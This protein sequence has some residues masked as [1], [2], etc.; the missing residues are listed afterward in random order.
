MFF[1]LKNKIFF[2]E[3]LFLTLLSFIPLLWFKKEQIIVGLDSGYAIDHVNYLMQRSNTW[4]GS[5]NFGV[6]MSSEVGIVPYNALPAIIK[7]LGVSDDFIQPILFVLWFFVLAI[8]MYL[9]S[10]CIFP[11]KNQW[12]ARM[13]S[14]II[15]IF[16]LHIYSFWLQG[17]QPIFASYAILP[18]FTMLFLR[19]AQRQSGILFT[20]IYLNLVYLFFSSGGMRGLPLIGPVIISS[21]LIIIYFFILSFKK[22]KFSY[23]FRFCKLAVVSIIFLFFCNAYFLLPFLSS[24]AF[25][26]DAQVVSAG[27]INSAIEWTKFI[28][29]YASFI[30]LFRLEGDPNWYDKPLIWS[31]NYLSNPILIFGSFIFPFLAFLSPLL[32]KKNQE[33]R[34]VLFFLLLS[35]LGVLFAAGAHMPL[36]FI[37][38]FLMEHIPGFASFRSAYYKFIPLVY[39]SFAILIGTTVYYLTGKIPK[40]KT[41]LRIG[42]ILLVLFYNY[43]FFSNS[44]FEF[45]KPFSTMVKI[46][47]YIREFSKFKNSTENDYRT[48]SVPPSSDAFSVKTFNWGYWSS[49]PIYSLITNKGFVGIGSFGYVN[50]ENILISSILNKLRRNNMEEFLSIAKITNV[51]Y[52][53]LTSDLAKD[54]KLSVSED[55]KV[56]ES[57]LESNKN[58]FKLVWEKGKWKYFEIIGDSPEKISALNGVILNNSSLGSSEEIISTKHFPFFTPIKGKVSPDLDYLHEFKEVSCITCIILNEDSGPTITAANITPASF[59]YRLKTIRENRMIANKQGE[60]RVNALLGLSAKRASELYKLASIPLESEKEWVKSV[61]MLNDYWKK[62]KK[63]YFDD[64]K[65]S[66]YYAVKKRI[67]SYLIIEK[68]IARNLIGSKVLTK[69]SDLGKV[70]HRF[71]LESSFFEKEI[72]NHLAT[73]YWSKNFVFNISGNASDIYYNINSLPRDFYDKPIY[74]VSY[75]I[76]KEVFSVPQ[77]GNSGFLYSGKKGNNLTLIFDLPNLFFAP[78]KKIVEIRGEAKECLV[79]DISKFSG[80]DKYLIS[81]V[82]SGSDKGT[83]YVE[84]QTDILQTSESKKDTLS[85]FSP[86]IVKDIYPLEENSFELLIQRRLNDKGL[87]VYF[88]TYQGINPSSSY[89]DISIIEVVS[90]QVYSLKKI[91]ESNIAL[92]DINYRNVSPSKYVVNV[93]NAKDSFV[94]YFSERYSPLWA[95]FIDGKRVSNHFTLNG[96]ANGWKIDKKGSYDMVIEFKTQRLFEVGVCIT[97]ISFIVLVFALIMLKSRKYV[98]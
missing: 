26:Y 50:N 9:L 79:S 17:E 75:K 31:Y 7:L 88:C 46:P 67:L 82:K 57:I 68:S 12:I 44:N 72:K 40:F 83:V 29:T 3:L 24:F 96:F 41:L 93:N 39:L 10:L 77:I 33:K 55:P 49:Y 62:I 47:D 43:P 51:K 53:L 63:A 23:F 86:E 56:Y 66:Q 94:L 80:N 6:D 74:P 54:Y 13:L 70:I 64:Y 8:S 89:K 91:S 21:S 11:K 81:A 69:S 27:G 48:I 30:N 92:P 52:V 98:K 28:S 18:L 71:V 37:Y 65:N 76:D 35:L 36:G 85:A 59:F 1:Y 97:L 38:T 14:V 34:L 20:A 42:L 15:Y 90:P 5:H 78:V 4:L 16:N 58:T 73:T 45:E 25:Q 19:F 84:R 87:V 95:L 61:E 60:E 2:F 22:E 32:V